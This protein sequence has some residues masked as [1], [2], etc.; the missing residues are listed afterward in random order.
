MN[1]LSVRAPPPLRPGF[2]GVRG[3]VSRSFPKSWP[4]IENPF[5]ILFFK[6]LVNSFV[7]YIF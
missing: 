1:A 3:W 7:L 4:S 6:F 5:N 2:W